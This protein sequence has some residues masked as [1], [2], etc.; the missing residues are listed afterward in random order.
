MAVEVDMR[1]LEGKFGLVVVIEIP[2]HPAIGVM[3]FVTVFRKPTLMRVIRLVT[4]DALAFGIAIFRCEM[5][6]LTGGDAVQTDEGEAR[7]VM[8]KKDLVAPTGCHVTVSAFLALFAFVHVIGAMAIDT[9][10][11]LDRI[12][13]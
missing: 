4:G 1:P 2:E 11:I 7:Q 9:V 3:A 10:G 8:V 13:I 12:H 6:G 5:A